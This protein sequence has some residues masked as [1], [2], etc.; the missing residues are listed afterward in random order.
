MSIFREPSLRVL[1]CALALASLGAS[2]GDDDRAN[3]GTVI[4][5]PAS[6]PN[7]ADAG[8]E[9]AASQGDGVPDARP[10]SG[11]PPLYAMMIQV[12]GTDDRTVYVHLSNTLDFGTTV[13]LAKTREFAGVAN[14]APVAGRILVSS[15]SAPAI[16]EYEISDD[17]Q[18][19]EGRTIGFA[20]YPLEDN[21]NFYAQFVFDEQT[22]YMPFDVTSRLLW[23]PTSMTI[24]QVVEDS[25]LELVRG[26][27][28]ARAGGNR[29]GIRFNGPVQ[30]AFIYADD[31]Y[32][33]FGPESVVA[34]YDPQSHAEKTLVPLP[35]PGLDM[36]SQDEQG[37]TYYASWNF[38]GTRALFGEGPKP[39]IA[40]LK[41]DLTL[42]EAWTTDLRDLT[43]GRHVNNFRYIGNGRAI[44]NVLDHEL[45]MAD[46]SGGYKQDIADKINKEGP[47]WRVWLFDLVKREAKPIEGVNV[48]TGMGTQFATLEGRT[49]L[50]VQYQAFGRTKIYEIASDG[51]ATEHADT[52][53]DVFK[54]VRIR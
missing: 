20:N 49:F 45:L 24:R 29:N 18:W 27:L 12:Y 7:T 6:D 54:W 34:I 35:C 38:Q 50:F 30:R 39:C 22:I 5:A 17:L 28:K 13:D 11:K 32:F 40:R 3:P 44:G 2:C 31:D 14:F 1:S 47:H 51:R 8:N 4:A 36:P 33:A 41:P 16:T 21:A 42:D 25:K 37:Y 10:A 23:N 46:W 9:P 53:G 52:P 48:T 26:G 15:G 19:R 43:G